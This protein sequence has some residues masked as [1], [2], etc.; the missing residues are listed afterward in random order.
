MNRGCTKK[1]VYAKHMQMTQPAVLGV[2][3]KTANISAQRVFNV[4]EA[5]CESAVENQETTTISS[6]ILWGKYRLR[7]LL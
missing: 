1:T 7:K 4:C 2:S 5:G 3:E 6:N